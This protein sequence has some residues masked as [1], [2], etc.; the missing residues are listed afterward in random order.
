M[1]DVAVLALPRE[2]LNRATVSSWIL[3][4]S[5][6]VV[7]AISAFERPLSA[8]TFGSFTVT[9]VEAALLATFVAALYVGV[10]HPHAVR[11]KTPIT[12]PIAVVLAVALVA[13]LAA[14]EFQS[15]ALRFW[16]RLVAA[17]LLFFLTL[18]VVSTRRLA[19]QL[20]AVLLFAGSIV[21]VLAVL[22]LMQ[23][24]W[25][26][27]G[28]RLFR[29]G[30]HVVGGQV[31]ATSTLFYPTITS[32]YLEV[33]FALGLFWLRSG[34]LPFIGLT[35]VGAGIISTFTRAG[36][37]TMTLSLITVGAAVFIRHR[38]WHR[39]HLR[40]AAL[41]TVLL[42]LMFV[43]RSPQMLVTR[44]ST[45]ASQEWYGADTACRRR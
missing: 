16:A 32:M 41:A 2:W 35:L 19:G 27:D 9:T 45:E 38:G 26:M 33:V 36:L 5:T 17:A 6:L 1:S 18:N 8:L 7:A 4:T 12:V 31:R 10:R 37:I 3:S 39:D 14:P 23:V 40:L 25:V 22:E 34:P 29:P 20:I 28:L 42:A 43:S 44:M 11:W 13:A 15:N 30:F 21:G 24:P